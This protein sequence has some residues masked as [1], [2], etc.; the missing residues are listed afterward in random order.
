EAAGTAALLLR[1]ETLGFL[2][3]GTE[4][5][6]GDSDCAS[7]ESVH[8]SGV[9]ADDFAFG[10]ENRTAAAAV[11]SGGIVDKFFAD[12]VAEMAARGGG[13][14]QRQCRQLTGGADVI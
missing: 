8:V 13:T 7:G 5:I 2:Q 4:R 11:G 14:D 10:V 9:D 1:Q 12:Y 6:D 3:Q